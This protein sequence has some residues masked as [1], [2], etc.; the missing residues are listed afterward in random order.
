[1][2]PSKEGRVFVVFSNP[3]AFKGAKQGTKTAY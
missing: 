3:A 1:M 2:E